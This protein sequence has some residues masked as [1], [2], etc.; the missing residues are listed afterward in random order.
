V[1]KNLTKAIL[2]VGVCAV[3]A[4]TPFASPLPVQAQ[5][6]GPNLLVDSDFEAPNPWVKQNGIDEVQIAPGWLAW[7]LDAPPSYVN[8]PDNCRKPTDGFHCYW[9]RPE[10]RTQVDFANRIHGGVRSQKYFSFGR[11]HEAGLYQQVGGITPGTTLRFSIY[12][13]SWM[14]YQIDKC[15]K[16]GIR[17]DWPTNMHLRVGI[18]PYGGSDPFSP[19]IVWSPEQDAFDQWVEFSVQA[20]A[21]GDTVT[22][23]T[24]SR[25]EWDWA[26]NNNDV[27]LDDASL[28]VVRPGAAAPT[29][30]QPSAQPTVSTPAPAAT[31]ASGTSAA[32]GTPR[33]HEVV[34][35]DTLF[36]L[37][38]TYNTTVQAIAQANNITNIN[39]IFV[40]QKLIIP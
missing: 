11:M 4:A 3:L 26:R 7:F 38:L 35:G 15:S 6:T 33:I 32:T 17:S 25:P 5:E 27:Y 28:V 14:C 31:P 19:N 36:A 29:A 23:F 9:M 13:Q 34:E 2:V 24:H 37:A 8:I 1:F 16:N 21:L 22:V 40:G 30:S 18:D 39:L 12:M 20:R 10:F